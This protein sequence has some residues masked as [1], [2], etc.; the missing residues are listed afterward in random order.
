MLKPLAEYLQTKSVQKET[1]VAAVPVLLIGLPTPFIVGLWCLRRALRN[2]GAADPLSLEAWY[3]ERIRRWRSIGKWLMILGAAGFVVAVV[4]IVA[5]AASGMVK[6]DA[7][8]TAMPDMNSPE[9]R[10]SL[11]SSGALV[12]AP[13]TIVFGWLLR[14]KR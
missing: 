10:A 13:M 11:I 9:F 8:D 4:A 5:L 3:Q 7:G 12:L 6:V 14:Q 2:A 1:I